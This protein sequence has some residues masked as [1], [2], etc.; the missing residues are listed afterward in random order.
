MV[1]L[2]KKKEEHDVLANSTFALS[3]WKKKWDEQ[4]EDHHYDRNKDGSDSKNGD[5]R[6]E[7]HSNR[8]KHQ[9]AKGPEQCEPK[10]ASTI[11]KPSPN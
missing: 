3:S 4:I 2:S 10:M 1:L 11:Q 8:K 6:E 7:G 9:V 5:G